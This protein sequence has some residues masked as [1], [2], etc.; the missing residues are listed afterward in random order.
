MLPTKSLAARKETS[1]P[2]YEKK[3]VTVLATSNACGTHKMRLTVIQSQ[4]HHLAFKNLQDKYSL[5]IWYTHQNKAWMNCDILKA[6]FSEFVPSAE[7]YFEN[8][9]SEKLFC[10]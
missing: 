9:D 7:K 6:V 1:A 2:G 10:Y 8:N 4:S 5:P 3:R